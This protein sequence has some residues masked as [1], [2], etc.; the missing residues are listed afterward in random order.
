MATPRA[1][2]VD[3]SKTAQFKLSKHL[4]AYDLQVDT[5]ISAEEA[6]GYL[7]YSMPAVIFMDHHMEGMDGLE[8]LR[9]IKDN[10]TTATIPVIMYTSQ[11]GD[12]YAGQ[13]AALGA[14]DI[15]SKEIMHPSS[16]EAALKKLSIFPKGKAEEAVVPA[17]EKTQDT[18][19]IPP[20]PVE[21]AAEPAPKPTPT[22]LNTEDFKTQVA[23]L[24]ELHI[25]DVRSQITENT[26]FMVRRISGEIKQA[27]KQPGDSSVETPPLSVL[28]EAVESKANKLGLASNAMLLL[29][30]AALGVIAFQQYRTQNELQGLEDSY[31]VLTEVN[32]QGNA[33]LDDMV[34]QLDGGATDTAA[35]TATVDLRL[36]NWALNADL[37]FEY[38]EA[39]LNQGQIINL[40]NLVFQLNNVGFSGLVE[41]DIHLGNFCL[42]ADGDNAWKLASNAINL[43]ECV[44]SQTLAATQATSN[45]VTLPYI[46]FE[47][48]TRPI[49]EGVIDI[50]LT[51]SEYEAPF[52]PYPTVGSSI[53]VDEWN[54]IAA[55]NNRLTILIDD[56]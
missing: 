15:I 49:Q 13:A 17:L 51:S 16:I 6:L 25:A 9:I 56:N 47:Q 29:I 44:F 21:T 41:L 12:V 42:E 5:A 18:V 45:Y 2:I 30:F 53:S 39:P 19:K 10:P 3:D 8:A 32:A 23:R 14:L 36:L 46:Q 38:G 35:E 52:Y 33:K 7:S 24:F 26:K 40:Q 27:T 50:L 1:L 48:T 31:T 4:K 54:H 22:D 20:P 34:D 37:S 43:D 11:Q 55:K 28:E